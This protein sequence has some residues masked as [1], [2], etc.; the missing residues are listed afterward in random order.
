[1]RKSIGEH[2]GLCRHGAGIYRR[3]MAS[4][5][6]STFHSFRITD[7]VITSPAPP[8]RRFSPR[9]YVVRRFMQGAAAA[10]AAAWRC[11]RR[12]A[13]PRRGEQPLTNGCGNTRFPRWT[14]RK[15]PM[16]NQQHPPGIAILRDATGRLALFINGQRSD[17]GGQGQL[18]LLACLLNRV[19]R[20]PISSW[21]QLSGASLTIGP[22]GTYCANTCWCS[23]KYCLQ[24]KRPLSS[25]QFKKSGTRFAKSPKIRAIHRGLGEATACRVWQKTCDIGASRPG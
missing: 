2:I 21:L 1:M 4:S 14:K 22:P 20:S 3:P 19:E 13:E 9:C 8:L 10:P 16:Q 6:R 24:I 7:P 15:T 23:V 11:W 25:R 18:A 12:C 17:R 5:V